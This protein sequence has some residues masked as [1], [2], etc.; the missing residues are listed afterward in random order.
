MKTQKENCCFHVLY[1]EITCRLKHRDG[2]EC[3]SQ[4]DGE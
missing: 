2:L 3:L 1:L 4:T